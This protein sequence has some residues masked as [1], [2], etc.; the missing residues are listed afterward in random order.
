MSI[1]VQWILIICCASVF[2][3]CD[4]LAAYWA[5]TAS[6]AALSIIIALSPFG[7]I[8]FGE[9]NKKLSLSISSGI[10]N[11]IIVLVTISIGIFYFEDELTARQVTGLILALGAVYCIS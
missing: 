11:S 9:L 6:Y 7:Y 4:S 1:L 2:V 8:L 5:K 10:V 3:I